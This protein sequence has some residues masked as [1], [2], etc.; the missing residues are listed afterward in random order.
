MSKIFLI[1][2]SD[3]LFD[4]ARPQRPGTPLYYW[5]TD[6]FVHFMGTM[7]YIYI[8]TINPKEENI[9]I[10]S[11]YTPQEFDTLHRCYLQYKDYCD[12]KLPSLNYAESGIAMTYDELTPAIILQARTYASGKDEWLQTEYEIIKP[13]KP[14]TKRIIKLFESPYDELFTGKP[15]LFSDIPEIVDL[16]PDINDLLPFKSISPDNNNNE[17]QYDGWNPMVSE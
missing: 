16:I 3:T 8:F 5:Y 10:R 7:E 1:H 12:G 4:V 11:R 14:F 17:Y 15:I 9:K 6:R 13:Y 2:N